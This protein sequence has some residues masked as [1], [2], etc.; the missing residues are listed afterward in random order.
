MDKIVEFSKLSDYLKFLGE[1]K[2]SN[3]S[4]VGEEAEGKCFLSQN[5]GYVYKIITNK[6]SNGTPIANY[7]I[8]KI[9]TTHDIKLEQYVLPEQLYVADNELIGYKTKYIKEKSIFDETN[10]KEIIKKLQE[11]KEKV[12]IEGYYKILEETDKL[13]KEQIEIYDLTYNLLFTGKEYYGIDTCGYERTK[14]TEF[15]YT[16]N[17]TYLE[18]AIK[19]NFYTIL[20]KLNIYSEKSLEELEYKE[21]MEEYA[22]GLIELVK[23]RI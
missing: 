19:E 20:T 1:N 5:D 4:I 22:K 18:E 11:L 13:S 2:C 15:L 7:D 12:L 10:P 6:D 14:E 9:I 17:R 8:S 23:K 21:N 16:Y 3:R